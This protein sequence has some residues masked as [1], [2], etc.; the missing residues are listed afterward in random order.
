MAT[1][2]GKAVRNDPD[3]MGTS[4]AGAAS[5][6][7]ITPASNPTQAIRS[8]PTPTMIDL[9]VMDML[10]AAWERPEPR[11]KFSDL[12]EYKVARIA[13][14]LSGETGECAIYPWQPRGDREHYVVVARNLDKLR[15]GYRQFLQ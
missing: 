15:A 10:H 9:I 7:T 4:A 12:H 1:L 13:I 11:S 6:A 5:V 2:S 14:T 8:N 3:G